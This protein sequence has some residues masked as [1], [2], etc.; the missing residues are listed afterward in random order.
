MPFQIPRVDGAGSIQIPRVLAATKKKSP[1]HPWVAKGVG[2]STRQ[3]YPTLKM[4]QRLA[5][6]GPNQRIEL[7]M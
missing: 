3:E 6:G 7:S 4:Q 2:I 1:D 5:R